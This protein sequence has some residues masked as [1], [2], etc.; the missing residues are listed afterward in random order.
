MNNQINANGFMAR[1][2][3]A[4]SNR[5]Q[6][7]SHENVPADTWA[8][9]S[10]LQITGTTCISDMGLIGQQPINK[11]YTPTL[12]DHIEQR[13]CRMKA[14]MDWLTKIKKQL[15]EPNGVLSVSVDDLQFAMYY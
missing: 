11:A 4:L 7:Q 10:T 9:G 15:S 13:M 14:D 12:A 6:K 2:D 5:A 3:N 1:I 8:S